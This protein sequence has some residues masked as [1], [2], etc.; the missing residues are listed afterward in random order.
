MTLKQTALRHRPAAFLLIILLCVLLF[1]AYLFTGGKYFTVYVSFPE[2]TVPE[3]TELLFGE[4]YDRTESDILSAGEIKLHGSYASVRLKAIA[5]GTEDV[6]LKVRFA[7][8]DSAVTTTNA[9]MASISTGAGNVILNNINRQL[10]FFLSAITLLSAVFYAV[11]FADAVKT[12]RFSYDTVFCLSLAL[13]FGLMTCI[14]GGA[15]AF[16]IYKY[17]TTAPD[18]VH[19]VNSNFMTAVTALTLP[20]TDRL[21]VI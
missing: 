12:K 14:W 5:R 18:I 11:C 2:N 20:L 19:S 3:K 1:A 8:S 13:L 4:K 16:S 21:S 10:Y 17:H 9:A 6:I 15:T 7:N